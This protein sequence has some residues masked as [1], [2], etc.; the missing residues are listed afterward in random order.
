MK[1]RRKIINHSLTQAVPPQNESFAIEREH[2]RN[3]FFPSAEAHGRNAR[4]ERA[5][6]RA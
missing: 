5:P 6:Y 4:R 3:N 1:L 2:R